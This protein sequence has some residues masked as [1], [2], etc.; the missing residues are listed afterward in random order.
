M[1]MRADTNANKKNI[2][3]KVKACG[4]LICIAGLSMYFAGQRMDRWR[5]ILDALDNKLD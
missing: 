3:K 2:S 4:A 1:P 5:D